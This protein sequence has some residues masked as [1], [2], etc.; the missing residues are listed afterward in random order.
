MEEEKIG[1]F[2]I[3]F[4]A[5]NGF[6]GMCWIKEVAT[7]YW[8]WNCWIVSVSFHWIDFFVEVG[9]FY[10]IKPRVFLCLCLILLWEG[11]MLEDISSMVDSSSFSSAVRS[12]MFFFL[13]FLCEF[14]LVLQE[15]FYLERS[16]TLESDILGSFLLRLFKVVD[17]TISF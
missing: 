4:C 17:Y 6:G 9:C 11:I 5:T 10:I 2:E 15:S 7:G 12:T 13:A 16:L 3:G 14:D 1:G 8:G